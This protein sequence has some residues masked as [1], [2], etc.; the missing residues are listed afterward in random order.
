MSMT[1]TLETDSDMPIDIASAIIKSRM[2]NLRYADAECYEQQKQCI[3]CDLEELA[4]HILDFVKCNR[5]I[6]EVLI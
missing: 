2:G 5:K 6:H 1:I 3:L 4:D